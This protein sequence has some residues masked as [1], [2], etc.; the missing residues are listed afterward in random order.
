MSHIS[1]AFR[2]LMPAPLTTHKFLIIWPDILAERVVLVA[3][4]TTYPAIKMGDVGIP[5]HGDV[6][7]RPTGHINTD[8]VWRVRVGEDFLMTVRECINKIQAKV[9]RDNYSFSGRVGSVKVM[10]PN[11]QDIPLPAFTL[12]GVWLLGR[13]STDIDSSDPTRPWKW[14]LEF[15]YASIEDDAVL[16]NGILVK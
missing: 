15:R 9:N 14:N 13:E 4:S 11:Q 1:T 12:R 5:F 16:D 10:I 7:Y 3:E 2:V 6:I 8:H